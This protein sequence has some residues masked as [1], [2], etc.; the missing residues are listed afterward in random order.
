VQ[1]SASPAPTSA[2]FPGHSLAGRPARPV[3]GRVLD[4]VQVRVD[5]S[6]PRDRGRGHLVR[7]QLA[8]GDEPGD[9]HRVVLAQRIIVE[10]V[11]SVGAHGR[12]PAA[13]GGSVVASV[14]AHRTQ[15]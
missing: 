4:G 3:V 9:G 6:G 13:A 7:A 10:R 14:V 12:A 8:P 15:V 2:S 5:D 1:T 11:D